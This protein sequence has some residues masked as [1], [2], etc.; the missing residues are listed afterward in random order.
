[1]GRK[2]NPRSKWKV[3]GTRVER[4]SVLAISTLGMLSVL[5][6]A[7]MCIDISHLYMAKVE[8]QDAAD[9]AAL[10]AASQLNSSSGGIK[11]AVA[12]AT[13]V[14]NKYDVKQ[15]VTIPD[16]AVTFPVN[17]N[18]TYMK[19]ANAY[20]NASNI[21][22]VKVEIPPQPVGMSLSALVLG[23]SQNIGAAAIAGMS[24]A[25]TMNKFYTALIFI[26]TDASGSGVLEPGKK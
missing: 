6:I 12:E 16:S 3:A 9:A 24:V 4:G 26:E 25:L 11:L 22:F 8:L 20:G 10:A 5:L 17:L 21:R 23:Q 2:M 19:E 14:L 13:K 15:N 7:G 18:G 1:M